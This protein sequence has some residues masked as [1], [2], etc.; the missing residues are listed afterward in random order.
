MDL[1]A[2]LGYAPGD[3]SPGRV[4]AAPDGV[5]AASRGRERAAAE[6]VKAMDDSSSMRLGGI[7]IFAV[8]LALALAACDEGGVLAPD[9]FRNPPEIRSRDGVLDA[10]LRV[11]PATAEVAGKTVEF[12]ALYDGLYMPPVLRVNPG[13]VVRLEIDNA[14]DETTNVHYHGLGVSPQPLGDDVFLRIDPAQT[15]RYD[16]PIPASHPAGL[17]WYHPHVHPGVN[18]EI[19]G[20]LS[21]GLVIGDILAPFP[22][23][24]DVPE[25]IL[26]LKDLKTRGGRPERNP[27]PAGPTTRTING[28][29]QPRIDMRP[30]QLEFWRI[31]NIGANIYYELSLGGQPF[32]VIAQDGN[33]QNR[34]IEYRTLLLP[35]GKRLEA[36]VYGPPAGTWRLEAAD[37]QTGPDGD[38]YPGQLMATVESSG[39][40]VDPIPLPDAFPVVRDLR[41]VPL[42]HDRVFDFND[43][44]DPNVFVINGRAYDENCVDTFVRLGDTERWTILN[45]SG[46]EHVFHIHQT[47][48]QVVERNGVEQ[49]FTGYQDTVNLPAATTDPATGETI[50]SRV[51]AIIPFTDPVIVG[52]FVYHCH[53]VQH[54][55]QGMMANILVYDPAQGVPDA[56]PCS[57]TGG[58]GHA[59]HAAP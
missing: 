31:G 45:S 15:Y 11:G 41:G 36:L 42:A 18:M 34:A 46:E 8:A 12:R 38:S 58:G 33:L 35:P 20:G 19:A 59:G 1:P 43:T 21:G 48:F 6:G 49:P 29:F 13:D 44:D 52:K 40:P 30:G 9:A 25:R 23:L 54:A 57:D 2:H 14:S 56:A 7:G 32:Y 4:P 10:T 37:Y 24:R 39:G 47:D 55:D 51:V 22:D 16:M 53:I 17:F 27:D 3:A 50:P 26:L 28:L 5:V